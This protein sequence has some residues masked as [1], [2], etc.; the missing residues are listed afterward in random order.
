VNCR[1]ARTKHDKNQAYDLHTVRTTVLERKETKPQKKKL[2]CVN[3]TTHIHTSTASMH[4][5]KASQLTLYFLFSLLYSITA[6]MW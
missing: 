5:L 1:K 4:I 3:Y 2:I 6:C